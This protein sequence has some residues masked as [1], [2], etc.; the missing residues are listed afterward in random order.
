MASAKPKQPSSLVVAAESFDE[1]LRRFSALGESL[2]RGALD[3]R[4]SLER[5]GEVLS[6]IAAC[7]EELQVQAHALI[8][9]LGAAR[10]A[11]E[12]EAAQVQARAQEIQAR[13]ETYAAIRGRFEAIGDAAAGLNTLAQGLATRRGIADQTLRDS[14]LPALLAQL[15]ELRERMGSVAEAAAQLE[16]DARGARFEDLARN[17][18]SLRQQLLAARNKI[19]LLREALVAAVPAKLIS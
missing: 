2:R 18:D 7:E 16:N 10:E 3:S 17:A 11:Q 14:E 12:T 4:Q 15:D 19:G 9:A 6:E 1:S 8:A 5:A 13:T